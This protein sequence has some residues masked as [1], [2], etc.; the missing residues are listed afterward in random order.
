MDI[1]KT[2]VTDEYIIRSI[3]SNDIDEWEKDSNYDKEAYAFA[4]AIIEKYKDC[5]VIEK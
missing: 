3:D 4:K 1:A 5:Y 2:F